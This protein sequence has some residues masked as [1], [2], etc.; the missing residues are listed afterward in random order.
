M[1]DLYTSFATSIALRDAGAVARE[2]GR[3]AILIELQPDYLPLIQRRLRAAQP[4]LL[5]DE[6][7]A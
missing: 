2:L 1:A 6:G 5:L 4:P 7:A 3:K